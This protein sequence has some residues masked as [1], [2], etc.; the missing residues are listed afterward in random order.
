MAC[1]ALI[2]APHGRDAA[3]AAALL[4]EIGVAATICGGLSEF[5]RCVNDDAAFALLTEEAV[6]FA[7]L[8]SL[9]TLLRAQPLWSDLPLVIMTHHGGGP[10]RNPRARRLSELLGNVTFLER[11]FHPVTFLS[12]ART[13]LRSRQRQ[14]EARTR[15]QELREGEERLRRLNET[16][17]ERVLA[18]TAELE[19]AH[20]AVL[21]EIAQRERTEARLRQSQKMETLGQ[22]TGGVA[23]DFNNLL[24]VVLSS[25]ELLG[26]YT[27]HDPRAVRLLKAAMEGAQR[28][29]T[30]TQRLL[31]FAHRQ[32][33]K[34]EPR[35][36]IDLIR[37]MAE[38]MG[39]SVGSAIELAIELPGTLPLVLVDANQIE[40]ALLNLVVN[41]RDAMPQ[42]GRLSIT[43]DGVQTAGD[44]DLAPGHYARVTVAD[45]GHGMDA[46]TLQRATEP[47]F[48]TKGVGKGTGLGL[49]MIHGLTAQLGGTLRLA[50]EPGRGTQVE[51]WLPTT[52]A[53]VAAAPIAPPEAAGST[54]A[55][56]TILLVDD[57]A[58][59]AMTTAA[60]L[61]DLGH[62]VIETHSGDH[63]L[64]VLREGQAIDLLITD[65]AMPKMNGAQLAKAVRGMRPDLPILLASGFA[66]LPDY[67]DADVPR[68][69]KPFQQDLLA[70]EIG[71]LVRPRAAKG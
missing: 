43:V 68:I 55:K 7:D 20:A 21:A 45:T 24:T 47:F 27:R 1:R 57:D 40:L 58:L 66:E 52:A 22:L 9:A 44:D 8:Q 19:A 37:G 61:E 3:V 62:E 67:R 69:S 26:R 51:L 36:L 25:L 28:G 4:Q 50:S 71:K 12:V 53:T 41:A 64:A 2:L 15:M 10:E 56:A 54:A 63:A 16:L 33:L 38:L 11:P 5:Q 13:A 18:R 23:H 34:V 14:Y 48:S 30:L 59:V 17:E 39:R 32:D 6:A 42:G 46:E 31:A 60:M 49:S 65:Y 70:R 29:A 35:N